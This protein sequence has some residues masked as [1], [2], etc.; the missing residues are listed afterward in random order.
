MLPNWAPALDAP[1]GS[2]F[3]ID[4]CW[5]AG[6][7]DALLATCALRAWTLERSL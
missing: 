2:L 3:G 7:V 1:S 4:T 6:W 5:R